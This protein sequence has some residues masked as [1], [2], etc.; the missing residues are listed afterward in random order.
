MSGSDDNTLKVWS[1]VTGKVSFFIYLNLY[2]FEG[3]YIIY[4][5][6]DSI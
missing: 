3:P 6:I 1:A 4:N 2:L 5:N